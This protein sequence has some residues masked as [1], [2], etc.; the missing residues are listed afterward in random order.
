MSK[1]LLSAIT[2]VIAVA[3][4]ILIAYSIVNQNFILLI[5][6]LISGITS[7]FLLSKYG[8]N[9]EDS[10]LSFEHLKDTRTPIGE[11]AVEKGMIT[12]NQLVKI[13]KEHSRTGER[14]GKIAVKRG[15]LTEKEVENLI[16]IQKERELISRE[17]YLN[18]NPAIKEKS[19]SNLSIP[20]KP[21][22]RVNYKSTKTT[23]LP[24]FRPTVNPKRES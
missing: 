12:V 1:N 9:K 7:V 11:I 8:E 20:P 16:K 21:P 3:S 24:S 4:A 6:V 15:F 14:F 23:P 10:L 18:K 17:K 19:V 2:F 22:N 13:L 5:I